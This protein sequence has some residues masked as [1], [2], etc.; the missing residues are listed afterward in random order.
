MSEPDYPFDGT[1]DIGTTMEVAS[2]VHWLRMPLPFKLDHINLWLL[3]DGDRWTIVDTGIWRD[4]VM[5][6]WQTIAAARFTDAKPLKRVI[7]T[8]FHP[9]HVGLAG[10]LCERFDVPLWMTLTE[11]TFGR[12]TRADA[13]EVLQE[14]FEKFYR[15]SG[16]DDE[17]IKAVEGRAGRYGRI[18]SPIPAAMRRLWD[19]EVFKIGDNSW[20]VIVGTGHAPEHACLYCK[21]LNVL[22][23]GDQ[24]LPRI[25]PNVAV[26]PQEPEAN[27]LDLYLKSLDRFRDLPEETLVLPSHDWPFRG[28]SGRIDYLTD[29]HEERLVDTLAA[30][31]DVVDG[32]GVLRRL[33]TR[34]LDDHQL[35][36][37]I[38]E[39][40][41][42][43]HHLIGQGRVQRETGADGIHR[44]RRVA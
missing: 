8:H 29:H 12:M 44:F 30:C 32:V 40:L 37:A 28:L 43:V 20:R 23:S 13:P 18:V 2:G 31:E 38:G 4:E 19:G 39:S 42:H 7:V 6:A 5:E 34:K 11:W 14:N 16:F 36:F 26:W 1:P 41:A 22:I 3:E 9:D 35:F 25:T 15:A 27:P 21:D 24:V 33:F 17:M 10:W